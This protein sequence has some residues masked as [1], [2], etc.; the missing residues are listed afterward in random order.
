MTPLLLA[1]CG[2][3]L[4]SA[5]A[6]ALGSILFRRLGDDVSAAGMNLGKDLIGLA[7][8]GVAVLAVGPTSMAPLSAALLF[9]SGVVGIALGDTL[10]FMA[11]V[12]LEPRRTLL[13]ATVGQV[14]T[15]ALAVGLLGDRPGGTTWLGIALVLGGVSWV[16]RESSDTAEDTPHGSARSGVLLGLGAALC[17]AAAT[18]LA[19]I[20]VESVSALQG[21]LVRLAGGVGG[22]VLWGLARRDL[23]GWLKPFRDGRLFRRL[24]VAETVIIFG[25]FWLGLWSLKHLDASIA[26]VLTSTEPLFVI[27]LGLWILGQ[28]P[29]RRGVVGAV[30]AV[31]GVALIVSGMRAGPGTEPAARVRSAIDDER[32][33]GQLVGELGVLADA[34]EG[35]DLPGRSG[36]RLFAP[37][38]TVR[39]LAGP[40]VP[41]PIGEALPEGEVRRWRD[42]GPAD[43]LDATS[44]S[45]LVA[46]RAALD[47]VT[48]AHLAIVRGD[49]VEGLFRTLVE[50]R[51]Q[52]AGPGGRVGLA[53][54]LELDWE[55]AEERWRIRRWTS[56]SARR[57]VSPSPLFVEDLR[58]AVPDEEL[59]ARLIRSEHEEQLRAWIQGPDDAWPHPWFSPESIDQHP[60]LAVVDVDRDG[61]DDL[62]VL[63]RIGRNVL[64]RN[65]GDGT[66]E[67][68]APAL[69]LDLEDHCSAAL[70]VDLD[71]DGDQDLIVGRTLVTSLVLRNEDGRFV[72]RTRDLVPNGLPALV[73]SVSAA[74]YNADGLLDVYIATYG[75]N[76]IEM[77]MESWDEQGG[78]VAEHA[79]LL[80]GFL[81]AD[82]AAELGRRFTED[83]LFLDRAGPRN[84]LLVNRGD[85]RLAPAPES[86]QLAVWRNS[87]QGTWA[88]YDQ[89]GRV[90]LYVANDFA[91]NNFF[92]NLGATGAAGSPGFADVTEE[93]GTA[94]VG[95]GMGASFGDVDGDGDLDLYVSNMFSKAGRRITTTLAGLTD[96]RL[97]KMAAGNT[98][99]E[100]REGRF[101]AVS[102]L[103]APAVLVERAGWSW[104]SQFFDADND[105]DLDL[106]A[107]AGYYTAPVEL[108]AGGDL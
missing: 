47:R 85:G 17:F 27:P 73:S 98:L 51:L 78:E 3:A 68:V 70:F 20:G 36:E 87:F 66:F 41:D 7:L 39:D 75:A 57:T 72:D 90:D 37:T 62:Y 50:L 94:D 18:I 74:D 95:F 40:G 26:T 82:E 28:R 105:G 71:N 64:L 54:E 45:L 32:L 55:R 33:I 29:S 2:A 31:A 10:F 77:E 24:L 34:L 61:H 1:A 25:G 13:L 88:D 107:P 16:M 79:P 14:F 11:L 99:F 92:R 56:V 15:V 52:G 19:K 60:G 91:P 96:R 80:A 93:T 21:T 9:L 22:L 46:P 58:R 35:G 43:A 59:R 65:R 63:A 86:A 84:H 48:D 104:G 101:E 100:N 97:P 81:P 38:V 8:L 49:H 44:L 106:Y 67:D 5:A 4:A 12:R 42:P 89:D 102:G 103:E 69:G 23:G 30:V 6:W 108:A 53:A 76:S 83:M